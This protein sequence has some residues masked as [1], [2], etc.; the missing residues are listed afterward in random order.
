MHDLRHIFA[1]LLINSGRTLY[2]VQHILEHT[3][4]KTTQRYARLSQDPLV[5]SANTATLSVGR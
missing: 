3:Q 4:I 5:A 2:E 1:S